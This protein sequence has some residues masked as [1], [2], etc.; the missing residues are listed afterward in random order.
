MWIKL[1][2]VISNSSPK[3]LRMYEMDVNE[4]KK[5]RLSPGTTWAGI[6]TSIGNLQ[7]SPTQLAHAVV[8]ADF[9][10]FRN[11]TFPGIG[12]LIQSHFIIDWGNTGFRLKTNAK[13]RLSDFV[14]TSMAGRVGQGITIL[15]AMSRKYKF[16]AHLRSHLEFK[17]INLKDTKGRLRP[18]G[19][20]L[21]SGPDRAIFESKASIASPTDDPSQIKTLL[22]NGLVKQVRP[23]LKLAPADKGF[24]VATYLREPKQSPSTMVFVDPSR[25]GNHKKESMNISDESIRREN[26]ASWLY[27]LGLIEEG[28]RLR[29]GVTEKLNEVDFAVFTVG[30]FQIAV[31]AL[32]VCPMFWT[33][34]VGPYVGQK[35]HVPGL[36]LEV[37]EAISALAHGEREQFLRYQGIEVTLAQQSEDNY[38]LLP[39]GTFFGNVD[40]FGVPE[41]LTLKL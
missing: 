19:D 18:I 6:T 36:Q 1:P 25:K 15:F 33:H 30:N 26:Y 31:P 16:S 38:S 7:F 21:F 8:K 39:D 2:N 28:D 3:S 41:L 37:L 5:K 13:S 40:R 24:V 4:V 20:F 22:R 32:N 29:S 12:F 34:K 9:L 17:K 14:L 27:A 11:P 35:P 10:Q 23:W